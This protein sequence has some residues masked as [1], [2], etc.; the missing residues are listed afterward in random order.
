MQILNAWVSGMN[1]R[2]FYS[3][4]EFYHKTFIVVKHNAMLE[5]QIKF[6]LIHQ[7]WYFFEQFVYSKE[8]F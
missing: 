6:R 7:T 1:F 5:F 3:K 4:S 8:G 2:T